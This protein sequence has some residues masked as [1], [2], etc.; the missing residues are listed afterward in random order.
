MN[1]KSELQSPYTG[2][3]SAFHR[4]V[5]GV[6]A[7]LQLTD[8]SRMYADVRLL[9]RKDVVLETSSLPSRIR[10][11]KVVE[12]RLLA[13]GD[14]TEVVIRRGVV[15]W[16]QATRG[17]YLTALFLD[18]DTPGSLMSRVWDD[19]RTEI[20]Y[21]SSVQVRVEHEGEDV[22][23][24]RLTNYSLNGMAVHTK[25]PL[26]IG[27][28]YDMNV[29]RSNSPLNVSAT[30]LWRVETSYGFVNGC[31]LK[32]GEGIILAERE[33]DDSIIPWELSQ[34]KEGTSNSSPLGQSLALQ[35]ARHNARCETTRTPGS[36]ESLTQ[37]IA[38][39]MVSGTLLA[40]ASGAV[41]AHFT[42]LAGLVGITAYIGLSWESWRREKVASESRAISL[43]RLKQHMAEPANLEIPPE[44]TAT[45]HQD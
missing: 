1:V 12:V 39:L 34:D 14:P 32:D 22:E 11:G 33:V 45:N 20:R 13:D 38:L 24:G 44:T 25:K 42:F 31:R 27:S 43:A 17:V 40:V 7:R 15:H 21:P 28:A 8:G 5:R 35:S 10:L 6:I 37:R 4:N 29:Q 19:R 18:E 36:A 2:P 23:T 16:K 26:K 3:S 30:C 9:T 41:S